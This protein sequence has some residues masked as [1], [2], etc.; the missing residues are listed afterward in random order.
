VKIDGSE[1][2]LRPE[3]GELP[4]ALL[5]GAHVIAVEWESDVGAH[6]STRAPA[7]DLGAPASNVTTRLSLPQDRWLL[8]VSDTGVGPVVLYWGEL[9]VFVLIAVLVSRLAFS[10]LKMH[11]WLLLGLGLSTFGWATLVLFALW[12]FAMRWRE[13][14]DGEVSVFRYRFVQIGLVLLTIAAIGGLV[15]AIPFGLLATPDMSVRGGDSSQQVLSWFVDQVPG[16]LPGPSAISISLW[17]YKAAILA[18]ALWLTTAL[19]KW[20]P[21]AWRAFSANG[22]WRGRVESPAKA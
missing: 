11:E 22:M 8:F 13:G 18:W 17:W 7:I 3:R 10:P 20:L 16:A 1:V 19:L 12:A 2:M 9:L 4:I 6:V 5:P 15:A 14:W 21:W